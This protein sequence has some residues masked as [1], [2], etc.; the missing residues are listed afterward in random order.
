MI[1]KCAFCDRRGNARQV[2]NILVHC[3]LDH[4]LEAAQWIREELASGATEENQ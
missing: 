4:V 3:C 2:E 1:V